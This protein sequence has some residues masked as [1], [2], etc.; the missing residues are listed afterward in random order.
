L[1]ELKKILIPPLKPFQ[2]GDR[3]GWDEL[4]S[5]LGTLLPQYKDF[6]SIYGTGAIDN[7]IWVLTPFT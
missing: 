5:S 3:N 4:E 7:F 6:I 2:T 1:E